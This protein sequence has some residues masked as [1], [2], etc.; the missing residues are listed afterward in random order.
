VAFGDPPVPPSRKPTAKPTWSDLKAKL[1]DFD[2]AK[3]LLLIGDLYS[4]SRENQTF[5][6]ARFNLG[7][8]PLKVY[9]ATISRWVYPDV[10]ERQGAS[11]AK[12][13]KAI[14]DYRKAVGKPEGL[15]ELMTFYCEQA[16]TF[17]AD[18][19]MD[20]ENFY[21][22]LVGMF[23]NALKT[24]GTLDAAARPPFLERLDAVRVRGHRFGYCVG[25]QMDDLLGRSV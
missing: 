4:A 12:A 14:T 6:H 10:F 19:G 18:I 9:K 24:V 1:A 22:A 23:G 21:N 11:V 8:D 2:R 25:D 13:K 5:L 15:A 7:E 16:S 3:L 17:A 20:D